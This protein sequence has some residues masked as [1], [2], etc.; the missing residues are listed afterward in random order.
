LEYDTKIKSKN[1]KAIINMG[2]VAYFDYNQKRE[3]RLQGQ[4]SDVND[5]Y[6][7]ISS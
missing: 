6:H 1:S 4:T 2:F 3:R 7:K 5:I